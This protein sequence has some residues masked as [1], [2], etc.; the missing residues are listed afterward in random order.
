MDV[1]QIRFDRMHP[2]VEAAQKRAEEDGDRLVA[3]MREAFNGT[4]VESLNGAF[5]KHAE[6]V[7]RGWHELA[8]EMV[9]KYSDNSDISSGDSPLS[10]PDEWL[11]G[12]G[13]TEGPPD[14]PVEDQ[15]PP[16]CPLPPTLVV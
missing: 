5:E 11:E 12:V 6:R 3:Q 14:A 16:K 7:L 15:C 13:Y 9:F 8:L 2:L 4:Y 10:Y 1:C